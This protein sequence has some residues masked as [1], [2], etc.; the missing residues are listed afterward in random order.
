MSTLL[1]QPLPQDQSCVRVVIHISIV[2]PGNA[3]P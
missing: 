1:F 3:I 2:F